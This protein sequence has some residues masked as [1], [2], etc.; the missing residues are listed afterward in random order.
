MNKK[1]K[2]ICVF[3]R[4]VVKIVI[5]SFG[6][7]KPKEGPKNRIQLLT[8]DRILL[9]FDIGLPNRSPASWQLQ[10]YFLAPDPKLFEYDFSLYFSNRQTNNPC[11]PGYVVPLPF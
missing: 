4:I 5:D 9:F 1:P 2:I 7:Q 8:P 11:H 3:N 6:D 10:I